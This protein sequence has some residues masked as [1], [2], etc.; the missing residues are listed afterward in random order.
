M[1]IE[2]PGLDLVQEGECL[3]CVITGPGLLE[4]YSFNI[5]YLLFLRRN[6]GRTL[7]RGSENICGMKETSGVCLALSRFTY[8]RMQT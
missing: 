1:F 6:I 2:N 7:S 5:I 3:V 4:D 8:R